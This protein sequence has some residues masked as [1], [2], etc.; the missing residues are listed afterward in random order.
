MRT[1]PQM[2]RRVHRPAYRQYDEL[3]VRT[4]THAVALRR[5]TNSPRARRRPDAHIRDLRSYLSAEPIETRAVTANSYKDKPALWIESYLRPRQPG[6]GS[7]AAYGERRA[8]RDDRDV[9]LAE[10]RRH[11]GLWVAIRGT[12]VL[13]SG[14][15]PPAVIEFLR[16]HGL[17]ADSVFR[18]PAD[19]RQDTVGE[20]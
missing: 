11:V 1:E 20:H 8:K 14:D 5:T 10:L 15:S 6:I 2:R 12:K 4:T 17:K 3:S 7:S 16:R 13:V 18:V 19:A 9:L